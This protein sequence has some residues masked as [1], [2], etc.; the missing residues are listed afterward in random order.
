MYNMQPMPPASLQTADERQMGMIMH[1]SQLVNVLFFPIGIVAPIVIWQTQKDKMPA[2]D[3]H[4]KM[5]TN[6]M[7]SMTIYMVVSIVLMFVLIGFLT[8]LAVAI[9]GIVFPIVGGI[10]ANNGELWSYPMTIKFLK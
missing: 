7:I 10:K 1:L 8:I 4:G 6:W 5:V 2:L 3:E 9:M